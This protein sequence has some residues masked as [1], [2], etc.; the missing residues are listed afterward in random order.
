MSP[1]HPWHMVAD[2]VN[3]ASAL[4]G[5]I[6]RPVSDRSEAFELTGESKTQ[7]EEAARIVTGAVAILERV[8]DREVGRYDQY[9]ALLEEVEG[10]A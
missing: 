2:A 8:R 7:L 4:I 10:H 5:E 3:V 6:P 9:Y 1:Y